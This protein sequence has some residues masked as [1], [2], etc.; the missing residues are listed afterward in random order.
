MSTLTTLLTICPAGTFL[1]AAPNAP[2]R[3][4]GISGVSPFSGTPGI[5]ALYL[6]A[7]VVKLLGFAR[8]S[9]NTWFAVAESVALKAIICN[10]AESSWR[11]NAAGFA[12]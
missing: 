6:R 5:F 4:S 9:F 10:F 2:K 7:Y 1:I 12:S 11:V 8:T 3:L